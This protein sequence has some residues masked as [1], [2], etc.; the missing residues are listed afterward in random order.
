[1]SATIHAVINPSHSGSHLFHL[2]EWCRRQYVFIL[3]FFSSRQNQVVEDVV[4]V[5]VVVVGETENRH[6]KKAS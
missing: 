2:Q 4:V 3:F 1:M 5:V 6:T